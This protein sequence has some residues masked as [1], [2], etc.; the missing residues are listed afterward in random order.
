YG[1][2]F[3]SLSG[4]VPAQD[5][6]ATRFIPARHFDQVNDLPSLRDWSPR[7]GVAYDLFGNGRTAI[8]SSIG[9]YLSKE[10]TGIP[11]ALN[12]LNTSVN[13][14]TRTWSD[15]NGNF[16]PDCNLPNPLA[17]GECGQISNLG[18][19]GTAVHT[20][21]ADDVLLGWGHRPASWDFTVDVQ[22]QIGNAISL[23]A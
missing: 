9:K 14:V 17:N 7:I 2:R 20:S 8:K 11:D 21:Y 13:S 23:T 10:G 15:A 19:G 5:T 4:F 6:A 1:V 12:P 18:F 22:Q 16:T 3:D